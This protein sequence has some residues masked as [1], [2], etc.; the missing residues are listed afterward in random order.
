ME[1][2]R[3]E[4]AEQTSSS[5]SSIE[6][7]LRTSSID[8]ALNSEGDLTPAESDSTASHCAS[9]PLEAFD[10]SDYEIRSEEAW[11]AL[12][13]DEVTHQQRGVP[14]LG[15]YKNAE[16]LGEWRACRAVAWETRP[17]PP[18]G[19]AT[20]GR[21]AVV[22]MNDST[23]GGSKMRSSLEGHI[24]AGRSNAADTEGKGG[25]YKESDAKIDAELASLVPGGNGIVSRLLRIHICFA[26]R[27]CQLCRQIS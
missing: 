5:T 8:Y 24:A 12:G 23:N 11:V 15:L 22:W 21:F 18:G 3:R 27:P 17:G 10:S 25:E 19:A 2:K 4:F 7:L 26:S 16:G 13:I 20:I 1:R 9:L 14:G 6:D